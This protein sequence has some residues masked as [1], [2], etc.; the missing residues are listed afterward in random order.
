M[1]NL[2]VTFGLIVGA[3]GSLLG[4]VI[5]YFVTVNINSI[6]HWIAATF[7]LKIWK[8][9]TYMFTRIPS[10]VD[11]AAVAW[12]IPVSILAAGLGALIPAITAA[13][14]QP[15]TLLRYE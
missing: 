9:S 6:E 10:E 4:V 2:F 3:I 13:R 5:G 1:A 15:V 14:M 7:G 11:W 12:I 8:A